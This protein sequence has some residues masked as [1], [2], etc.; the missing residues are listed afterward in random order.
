MRSASG[1]L[2]GF[3]SPTA[4]S[5]FPTPPLL[6]WGLPPHPYSYTWLRQ[7][8]LEVVMGKKNFQKGLHTRPLVGILGVAGT[9]QEPVSNF[10]NGVCYSLGITF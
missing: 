7:E 6:T 9:A 2:S 3:P 5:R 10:E 8:P 4:V 1:F